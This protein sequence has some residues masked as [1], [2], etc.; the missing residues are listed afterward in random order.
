[1]QLPDRPRKHVDGAMKALPRPSRASGG[2]GPMFRVGSAVAAGLLVLGLTSGA[3]ATT[4]PDARTTS[5]SSGSAT[6]RIVAA[7]NAFLRVLDDAERD[8]VLF[9]RGDTAQ[10]QRWSNLPS[11]L[12]QRAGLMVRDLDEQKVLAFLAVMRATLSTEGYSRV[13]AARAA[14]DVLAAGNTTGLDFGSQFFW[15][16]IIGE[17]SATKPWQWQFGGHHLTVNAT[18]EGDKLSLT[19]T[20][21]GVQPGTYT[22]SDGTTVRPLGDITDKAF[23]L[24]NLLHGSARGRAVLG[25]T[26]IDVVLGPGQDCRTLSPEGLPGSAMTAAQRA[27]FLTLIDEYSG[28][29]HNQAAA[30]RRKQLK[31]DLADTYFAWYGPTTPGSAAYFRIT[32]PHVV[33]EYAPNSLGG[34]N[35]NP[36]NHTHGMYRDPTNDYGGTVC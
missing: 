16:A 26:Y 17:P 29:A 32:G 5:S 13:M 35:G 10:R 6:A 23:A 24:V 27:T 28:L 1:M 19:P 22:A 34:G 15:I 12:F 14:D 21:L 3:A 11:P 31:K 2:H 9:E 20:V 8:A 33:I 7:A 25:D 18:I 30:A 36:A 4:R